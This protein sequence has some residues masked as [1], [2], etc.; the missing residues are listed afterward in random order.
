MRTS[1]KRKL[2]HD[3]QEFGWMDG[4]SKWRVMWLY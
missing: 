2:I 4:L 1:R 3:T